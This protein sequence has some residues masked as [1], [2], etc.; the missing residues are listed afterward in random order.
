MCS[1]VLVGEESAKSSQSSPS[2]SKKVRDGVGKGREGVAQVMSSKA[3]T[4]T[5][6]EGAVSRT[7]ELRLRECQCA[8]TLIL[9]EK[10]VVL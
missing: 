3:V 5:V 9:Q 4:G 7:S 1:A 2:A 8:W 6:E 10:G